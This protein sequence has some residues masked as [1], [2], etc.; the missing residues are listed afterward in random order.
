MLCY[1]LWIK[2]SGPDWNILSSIIVVTLPI[3]QFYLPATVTSYWANYILYKSKG[4]N[5]VCMNKIEVG[6]NIL[7]DVKDTWCMKS[8]T[9]C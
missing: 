5:S 8:A 1:A 2:T 3:C 9:S 6:D 4:W 7:L